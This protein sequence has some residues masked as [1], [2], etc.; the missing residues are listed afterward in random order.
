MEVLQKPLML[1]TINT[2]YVERTH[3]LPTHCGHY[4]ANNCPT[5]NIFPP[6][7]KISW[8]EDNGTTPVFASCHHVMVTLTTVHPEAQLLRQV[9]Y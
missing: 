4:W 6:N 9:L 3:S 8:C 7:H 5:L 2:A 1:L